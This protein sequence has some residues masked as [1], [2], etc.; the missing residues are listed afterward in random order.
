M[1]SLVS[2]ILPIVALFQI[3]DGLSACISGVLRARGKQVAGALLNLSAYYVIGIP[4]G[5]WLCF[6]QGMQLM[7]LWMGLT[8]SLVYCS[9]VGL[10]MC[11]RTNW[12]TE[13]EKVNLRVQKERI[14]DERFRALAA[15]EA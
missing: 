3:V 4:F 11:L 7:G 14:E 10:W 9:I 5:L 15:G 2:S 1:I 13:V 12:G 8:V 6:S